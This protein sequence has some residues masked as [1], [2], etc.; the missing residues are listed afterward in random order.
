M[1]RTIIV[2]NDFS[3]TAINAMDYACHLA[4]DAGADVLM[5]HIYTLPVSYSS[6]AVALSLLKDDYNN[7]EERYEHD[8]LALKQRYPQI[9]VAGRMLT[10]GLI[11]CLREQLDETDTELV[12][13]GAPKNYDELWTW[14][15][16]L[17]NSLTSL[18]VPVLLIPVNIQYKAISRIGFACDYQT[19]L[20]PRQVNFIRL[21]LNTTNAQLHVVH[22]ATKA[23]EN[24][25]IAHENEAMIG[26]LLKGVAPQYHT[27]ES[28]EVIESISHFVIDNHI[29]FLIV[30]PHRH[31]LWYN[32]FHQ[33]HTKQLARLNHIP[34]LALQ[35]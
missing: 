28:K 1:K 12:V 27:L 4:A 16:E 20:I 22:V 30:I 24:T 15:N 34:I 9:G 13:M 10:G 3:E 19:L 8:L 25:H 5:L 32:I 6:D 2:V 29:D 23:P 33:S 7:A 31:G 14:D 18:S 26:E 17:L 35:D 21:L 11:D